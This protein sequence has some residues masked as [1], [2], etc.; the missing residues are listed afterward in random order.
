[1]KQLLIIF[2]TVFI[3]EVGDKT[4]L[5]TMLFATESHVSKAGVFLAASAALVSATLIAVIAGSVIT[6]VVAESTLKIA[7]GIGFILVGIWTL[8][9]AGR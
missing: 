1:M 6:R 9:S 7:A 5:A 4:Q 3:A 8:A 2:V